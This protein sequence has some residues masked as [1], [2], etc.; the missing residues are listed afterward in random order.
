MNQCNNEHAAKVWQFSHISLSIIDVVVYN[1]IKEEDA[2]I[3]QPH[4]SLRFGSNL[5]VKLN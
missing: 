4:R 2:L 5:A 1:T 3:G